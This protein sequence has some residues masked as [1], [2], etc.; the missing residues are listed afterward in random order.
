MIAGF[1]FIL[2]GR[3]ITTP[4]VEGIGEI[5]IAPPA[6]AKLGRIPYFLGF[7]P[8]ASCL[9]AANF[10]SLENAILCSVE[11]LSFFRDSLKAR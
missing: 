7:V 3:S 8:Q 5:Q 9:P 2:A 11:F 1:F 10:L 6:L 4:L